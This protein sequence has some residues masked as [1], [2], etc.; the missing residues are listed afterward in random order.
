MKNKI[1]Y[2]VL[3]LSSTITFSQIDNLTMFINGVM[4]EVK[5]P[6]IDD[7][8]KKD[9]LALRKTLHLIY[10]TPSFQN[11][12]IDKNKKKYQLRYNIY[13]DEMEFIRDGKTYYTYKE[14]NQIINFIDLKKVFKILKYKENLN[15]YQIKIEGKYS[16]YTKLNVQFNQGRPPKNNFE[17]NIPASYVK[18]E[19]KIFVSFNNNELIKLPKKKKGF[20]KIFGSESNQVKKFMKSNKL[21][22]KKTE[23]LVILFK[24]LNS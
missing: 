2:T 6:S 8:L 9:N 11:A 20:Y 21:D 19:D 17:I 1:I 12:Q 10:L 23:D 16:L 14:E 18:K 13:Q 5:P 4:V 22:R 24:H 15:Y 3:L 7:V